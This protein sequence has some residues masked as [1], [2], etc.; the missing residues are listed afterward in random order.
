MLFFVDSTTLPQ[1]LDTTM[2]D[3][4]IEKCS[5]YKLLSSYLKLPFEMLLQIQISFSCAYYMLL[6]CMLT[7]T[8]TNSA[9]SVS[10]ALANFK[11]IS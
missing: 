5:R 6:R 3:E 4:N 11:C 8:M 10:S 7:E 1:E 2:Y 9:I